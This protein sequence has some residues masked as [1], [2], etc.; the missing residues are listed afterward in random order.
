[1][2]GYWLIMKLIVTKFIEALGKIRR[3]Y[4]KYVIAMIE[5]EVCISGILMN[6]VLR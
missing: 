5:D 3:L 6:H 1:M 4:G 2:I